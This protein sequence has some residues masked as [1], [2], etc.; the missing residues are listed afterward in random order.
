MDNIHNN[1]HLLFELVQPF[2]SFSDANRARVCRAVPWDQAGALE[3]C[4]REKMQHGPLTIYQL[5]R[6]YVACP[7]KLER[8]LLRIL[9]RSYDHWPWLL[10]KGYASSCSFR[11]AWASRKRKRQDIEARFDKFASVAEVFDDREAQPLL[12]S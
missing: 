1:I 6:F 5:E 3:W 9:A 2:L 7:V 4:L 12:A 10:M 11:K 8:K